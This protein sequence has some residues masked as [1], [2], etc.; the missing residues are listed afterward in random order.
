MP[1]SDAGFKIAARVSGRELAAM[2]GVPCDSW[3]PVVSEVQ[4]TERL[5]DRVFEARQGGHRFLVYM[6]AY[7]NWN[8]TV[9]WSILS[10][11]GLL[12]ER[13]RL[14]TVSVVYVLRP[15]GYRPQ[16]GHFRLEVADEPTQQIWFHEIC[17]WQ[18]EPQAWWDEVPGLMALS[19]LCHQERSPHDVLTHAAEAIVARTP[20]AIERAN[21]L[22]TLAIFGKLAYPRTDVVGLIGREQM[23]ESKIIEEFQEEARLE[24]GREDVLQV[25]DA[26]FGARAAAE[27][28]PLLSTMNDSDSL[29]RLLRLAAKSAALK[30]FRDQFEKS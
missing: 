22:T 30:Q 13:E 2:A 1:A 16:G 14:P 15:R 19:P 28:A 5:A 4:T 29:D 25:L 12:S 27:F 20:D 10:K 7:T 26:R 8:A 18:Q 17:L 3:T 24:K 21:L 9:P 6:E 23:K 11:S